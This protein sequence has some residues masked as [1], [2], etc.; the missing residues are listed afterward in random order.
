[1]CA[2]FASLHR[3][4]FYHNQANTTRQKKE[5][6]EKKREEKGRK[7]LL[8]ATALLSTAPAPAPAT[9]TTKK[10]LGI[11]QSS[12]VYEE[13]KKTQPSLPVLFFSSH[14]CPSLHFTLIK[15]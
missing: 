1:M 2:Y 7:F 5:R 14:L 6:K 8:H 15:K 10:T 4:H 13:K 12:I 11:N 9:A 3:I